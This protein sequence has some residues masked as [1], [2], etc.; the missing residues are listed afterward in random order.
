MI[1][2][3][4][5]IELSKDIHIF[6]IVINLLIGAIV[7]EEVKICII[8]GKV[9]QEIQFH[10]QV[11]RVYDFSSIYFITNDGFCCN[12]VSVGSLICRS[13]LLHSY[14]SSGPSFNAW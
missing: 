6:C 8:V 1:I 13:C 14:M 2:N 10:S 11:C 7:T 9:K 4:K 3:L 12:C 5:Y